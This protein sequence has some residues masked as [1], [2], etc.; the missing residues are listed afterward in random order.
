MEL[1]T[2]EKF[3]S[4]CNWPLV[5]TIGAFDGIH[6]AHKV[7]IEK[8][9]S[10]AKE[11]NYK[12]AVITF[13][14]HPLAVLNTSIDSNNINSLENKFKLISKFDID[15]L[16]IIN[17]TKEFSLITKEEFVSNYLLSINVK[18]VI[19]GS[20]FKF[21]A[22][23][24][25]KANDIRQ[26]S[27]NQIN[28]QIIDILKMNDEKIGSSK[29]KE[30]LSMGNIEQVNNMLGYEFFFTGKVVKGRQVGRTLGFPTAN[31][32]NSYISK[33]LATGVYGVKVKYL[34]HC[35][36]GMMNIG[37]NPTCNFTDVLS[38]E[39]NLFD[40]D[41]DLYDKII[42]I[43]CF[44]YVRSEVKFENK[45]ELINRLNLDKEIIINKNLMLAKKCEK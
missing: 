6:L 45:E 27:N 1:I 26:L 42:E 15:Y 23:G 37:H 25:G 29:I 24:N 36:L 11:L 4:M 44:C 3:K 13:D 8:T 31:I 16:I 38:I 5:V 32:E 19:V 14:P 30:L 2:F 18:E 22:N 35:Y 12:S 7:L 9:F 17:F 39:V 10:K 34:D 21:G 20:D 40:V 41:I 43:V 28:V 33:I